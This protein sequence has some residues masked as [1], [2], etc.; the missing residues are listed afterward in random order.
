MIWSRSVGFGRALLGDDER[1]EPRMREN[2]R[3]GGRKVE[4]EEAEEV[5]G[6]KKRDDIRAM[7]RITASEAKQ[8]KLL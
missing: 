6:G 7:G 5:K 8:S 2:V 1:G 4:G 3:R